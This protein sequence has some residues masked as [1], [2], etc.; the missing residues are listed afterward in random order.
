MASRAAVSAFC[1]LSAR[2]P[3]PPAISSC[4]LEMKSRMPVTRFRISDMV[5]LLPPE[6]FGLP[7]LPSPVTALLPDELSSPRVTSLDCDREG[8]WPSPSAISFVY[9]FFPSFPFRELG[10]LPPFRG[11]AGWFGGGVSSDAAWDGGSKDCAAGSVLLGTDDREGGISSPGSESR[12]GVSTH[13]TAGTDELTIN[14]SA[15]SPSFSLHLGILPR[16]LLL[17]AKFFLAV[18]PCG[19]PP[20]LLRPA[21]SCMSAI[22]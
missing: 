14:P 22:V 12:R 4:V 2:G 11:G 1:T 21:T 9:W 8:D 15:L 20:D 18:I 17:F 7:G 3:T 5:I 10:G 16:S 13:Q 19:S 6:P